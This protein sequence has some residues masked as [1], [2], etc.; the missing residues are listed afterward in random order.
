[1]PLTF[2]VVSLM[3]AKENGKTIE[4]RHVQVGSINPHQHITELLEAIQ[5]ERHA[6]SLGRRACQL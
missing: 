6:L 5:A 3:F 4:Y 2:Q 1:M